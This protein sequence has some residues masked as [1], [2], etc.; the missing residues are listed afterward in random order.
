MVKV[1]GP[2][3]S[4]SASGTIGKDLEY[5]K[6]KHGPVVTRQHYPGSINPSHPSTAQL[7]QREKYS[8]VASRWKLIPLLE[9]DDYNNRAKAKKITGWN[10]YLSEQLRIS[11]SSGQPP[12]GSLVNRSTPLGSVT[13]AAYLFNGAGSIIT[14]SSGLD[15]HGLMSGN[16]VQQRIN[17]DL[18]FALSNKNIGTGHAELLTI[19]YPEL[20]PEFTIFAVVRNPGGIVP[21]STPQVLFSC[22]T[23]PAATVSAYITNGT[24]LN[25]LIRTSGGNRTISINS[26]I[27][28]GINNN[29]HYVFFRFDGVNMHIHTSTMGNPGYIQGSV[30][31]TINQWPANTIVGGDPSGYPWAGDINHIQ[32]FKKSL[33]DT[34]I[35]A[36]IAN[37]YL[38]Y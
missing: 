22:G 19:P 6:T 25:L 23:Q 33:N 27:T 21:L 26:N 38:T 20:S 14:D 31:G 15:R 34:E 9:R 10:L 2:L 8:D 35:I 5:R 4:Q 17:T 3:M 36:L 12:F 1:V 18:G 11:S 29:W 28:L 37:R 7:E 13:S 30:P 32:V 24:A 16:P